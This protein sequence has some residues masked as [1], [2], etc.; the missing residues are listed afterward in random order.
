MKFFPPS[1]KR[2]LILMF[3]GT[4]FIIYYALAYILQYAID[5]HFYEQDYDHLLTK[6]QAIDSASLREPESLINN[7]NNSS[8]FL[9]LTKNGEV[10]DQNSTISVPLEQLTT[11]LNLKSAK[12]PLEWHANTLSLRAFVFPINNDYAL[13]MGAN[14]NHHVNFISEFKMILFWSLGLALAISVLY[15]IFIVNRGLQPI[16]I[17]GEHLKEVSPKNLNKRIPTEELPIELQ[18]L[19]HAQNK[20][21]E[22]LEQGFMRLSEFSSDIAHELRTPLTNINTQNQVIL[23][24]KRSTEEYQDALAS[25]LEELNRIIKTINDIL[26]I[27]KAENALIHHDNK[28]IRVENELQRIVEYF[29]I[30]GEEKGLRIQ[31]SGKAKLNIDKNMFERAIN[32]LLS[33]AVRHASEN[34]VIDINVKDK[35]SD[36]QISV[37]NEGQTIPTESINYLFDR[38]Y[39]VDKSRQY[40]HSI[41]AGLGLSI[42][43]SIVEAYNGHVN[44]K[45]E[46]GITSFT[47]S[48]PK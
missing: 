18:E 1:M 36:T 21:L 2:N 17:L 22:R 23:S 29:D 15:S 33:N 10:K 35:V 45:S 3:L 9:W 5:Q 38:F 40:K 41:G 14:I 4:T 46:N 7:L 8:A 20:M 44:V 47:L 27:A 12:T 25:N 31:Y 48:F 6:F 39:R 43:Q 32:N 13:V 26:Y 19:S 28:T 11:I 42:T 34:T 16:K 30:I 24:S 37:T